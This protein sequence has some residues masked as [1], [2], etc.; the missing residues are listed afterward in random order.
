MER[1]FE[2]QGVDYC[3]EGEDSGAK[4]HV[5]GDLFRSKHSV[6]MQL[7]K[8]TKKRRVNIHDIRAS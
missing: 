7:K 2:T 8:K 6:N 1:R 3:S 5:E 4:V